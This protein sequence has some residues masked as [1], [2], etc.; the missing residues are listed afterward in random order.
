LTGAS[1]LQSPGYL[2]RFQNQTP[3]SKRCLGKAVAFRR[4]ACEQI[5][6]GAA[7][8]VPQAEAL[9]LAIGDVPPQHEAELNRWYDQEHLPLLAKV[10]G[11][12]SARRFFDLNGKPRYVALY[13]LA[14]AAAPTRAEWRSALETPWA[15]KIDEI[16]GDME[17]ILRTY[18]AYTKGTAL[19]T[20]T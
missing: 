17:W 3:W 5:T 7:P 6:P 4:W 20:S 16:T 9:F 15:K 18:R 10:P 8:D 14:D 13:E 1:V 2:Q 19:G 11:V 12:L